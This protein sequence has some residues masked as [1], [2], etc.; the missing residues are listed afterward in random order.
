MVVFHLIGSLE[1]FRTFQSL[2]VSVFLNPEN[3]SVRIIR[4]D[5]CLIAKV[6]SG[7]AEQGERLFQ[8]EGAVENGKRILELTRILYPEHG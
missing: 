8:I 7:I 4:F 5:P 6:F 1:I 3:L 2:T